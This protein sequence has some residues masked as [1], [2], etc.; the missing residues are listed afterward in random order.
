MPKQQAPEQSSEPMTIMPVIPVPCQTV[1]AIPIEDALPGLLGVVKNAG[2]ALWRRTGSALS[3]SPAAGLVPSALSHTLT[4]TLAKTLGPLARGG[5]VAAQ[6]R[7]GYHLIEAGTPQAFAE[8]FQWFRLGARNGDAACQYALGVLYANG[9]GVMQGKIQASLWYLKAAAQ[10]H[11]AAQF[12]LG[13]LYA[14]GDGVAQDLAQAVSWYEKA[15]E[16]GYP[17]AQFN[18]AVMLETGSGG[19]P[20]TDRALDLYL[21][22]AHLGFGL[23][24]L[25]LGEIALEKAMNA[26]DIASAHFWFNAA[27]ETLSPGDDHETALR[28]RDSTAPSEAD[29]ATRYPSL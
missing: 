2:T 17:R 5:S 8:A 15:A 11:A 19:P 22:A 10:G 1:H 23:A 25:R 14:T 29:L 4:W 9:Q 26:T 27:A 24:C 3:A 20:D 13:L 7:L 28:L 12:N 18:L 21:K 6:R 16:Q